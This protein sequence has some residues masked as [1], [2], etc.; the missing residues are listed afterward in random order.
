MRTCA[1]FAAR[2]MELW[3]TFQK[4]RSARTYRHFP[5][6]LLVAAAAISDQRTSRSSKDLS[7]EFAI[8]PH[9][10][11]LHA[12]LTQRTTASVASDGFVL[13]QIFVD[14]GACRWM[15]LINFSNNRK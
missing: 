4:P 11:P 5:L 15:T 7:W 1:R 9:V 10:R 12:H 3:S 6:V 14:V 13:K 8:T 2:T